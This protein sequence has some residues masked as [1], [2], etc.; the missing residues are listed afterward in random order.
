MLGLTLVFHNTKYIKYFVPLDTMTRNTV[1]V[2]MTIPTTWVFFRHN[3]LTISRG[4]DS[5]GYMN[6]PF[7]DTFLSTGASSC[8][9]RLRHQT[10]KTC[11]H[12]VSW[13]PLLRPVISRT[14]YRHTGFSAQPSV[15]SPLP[16]P[17]PGSLGVSLVELS[18][19]RKD[20]VLLYIRD[21]RKRHAASTCS[22]L[23]TD[24]GCL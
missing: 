20:F 5:L 8:T 17:S 7:G 11:C 15:P 19:E 13:W 24:G 22:A 14:C 9:V 10:P 18:L 1:F 6:I 3:A 16:S 12:S 4:E 21:M 23:Q 2:F